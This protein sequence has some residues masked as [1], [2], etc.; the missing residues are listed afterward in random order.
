MIPPNY[1]F[2]LLLPGES[3]RWFRAHKKKFSSTLFKI[4]ACVPRGGRSHVSHIVVVGPLT[5]H[6]REDG[7]LFLSKR[8]S[9]ANRSFLHC[10]MWLKLFFPTLSITILA[11]SGQVRYPRTALVVS[12]LQSQ[13]SDISLSHPSYSSGGRGV[14]Y[15]TV[16]LFKDK[17]RRTGNR[18]RHYILLLYFQGT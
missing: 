11:C 4:F 18:C 5:T 10:F 14:L 8:F 3:R 16:M 7:A 15:G 6:P 17:K 9:R 12:F 2:Y 1:S 13:D